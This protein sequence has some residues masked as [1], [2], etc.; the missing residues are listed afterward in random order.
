MR[1]EKPP[2][3]PPDSFRRGFLFLF[4]MTRSRVFR[5]GLSELVRASC[6]TDRH[7]FDHAYSAVDRQD[8]FM[9]I[10]R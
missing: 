9:R 6:A 4:V 10:P 2:R 5:D 1:C 7:E 3:K 8:S